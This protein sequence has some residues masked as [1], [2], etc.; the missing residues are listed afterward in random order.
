MS[1]VKA[2]RWSLDSVYPGFDS[3]EYAG[4]K[5]EL[6]ALAV[7]LLAHLESVPAPTAGLDAFAPWLSEA[8]AIQNRSA[9]LSTTLQSY[10]YAAYSVDTTSKRAMNELNAIEEIS[11][12]FSRAE[13]LYLDAIA[14]RADLVRQAIERDPAIARYRFPLEDGIFWQTRQMSAAEEDLAADLARSGSSAWGRLHDQLTATADTVWDEASGERKTLTELRAL[15]HE[16]DRAVREKAWL[17]ELQ[18][19]KSIAV[20]VAASLNGIK[21]ATIALN[22]RRHWEGGSFDAAIEKSVRQGQL[23]RK[24]LDALIAA[25]EES[26]PEW[27]RYLKAKASLVGAERCAFYDL[28]APVGKEGRSFTFDEAREKV[29]ENFTRFSP[30][31][32]NFATRAFDSAWIDAEPRNGKIGGAYFTEMPAVK[33]GR[34][35]C[36]FDGTFD[37]VMTLAHELGHAFHA[38]VLKNEPPLLQTVPMTLAETASIFAETVVFEDEMARADPASKLSLLETHV[39]DGCQIIVDILSRYY[40]E[41]SVFERRKDG[42]LTPDDFCALM[43][44]AQR[45]TYGDGLN[46]ELLH[47]YMWVVKVHYYSE[48]LAFYNFPYA[49]GQLFALALYGRYRQEGAPF[50]K[51]YESVL[52]DTGRMNA[53]EVTKRAGF[54]IESPAFWKSGID[55]FIEQIDEFCGL[56]GAS[57][58]RASASKETS[59]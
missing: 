13:V 36:N 8:I 45:R 6:G 58:A 11:L 25:M 15:A 54:D 14:T 51:T 42:E 2:P 43:A 50:A 4:A 32:G 28:F 27:R 53:V 12:P 44:D 37:S 17:K 49:F 22:G 3:A 56:V 21:G 1:D 23:T 35:M 57:S 26:L 52:L 10:C 16:S 5:R 38:D 18:V 31:M 59:K 34:V 39:S 46:P 7:E 41:R 24:A 48:D 19:C 40:F 33:E 47:P 29:V 55:I 20:P 30:S 9:E